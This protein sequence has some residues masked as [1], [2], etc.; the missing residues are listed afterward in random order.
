MN[1]PLSPRDCNQCGKCE[2]H[3]PQNIPIRKS[4]KKAARRFEPLPIRGAFALARK[5]LAR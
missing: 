3:C 5:F 2:R 4:L 1:K